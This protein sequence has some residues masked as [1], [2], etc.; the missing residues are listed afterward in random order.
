MPKNRNDLILGVL[1]CLGK[2]SAGQ[3]PAVEDTARIDAKLNPIVR[4]LAA[5][6]FVYIP[7]LDAIPDEWFPSLC[8]II[9]ERCKT[10]FPLAPEDQAQLVEDSGVS[11]LRLKVMTRGKPTYAVLEQEPF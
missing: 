2:E 1:D 7:D 6:E 4:E 9:A 8:D 11:M 3:T 10:V 5:I